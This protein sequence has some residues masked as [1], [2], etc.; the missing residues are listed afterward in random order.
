VRPLLNPQVLARK[1]Q[2]MSI[3]SAASSADLPRH[4][5]LAPWALSP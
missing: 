5:A 4:G 2:P 1:F 3:S